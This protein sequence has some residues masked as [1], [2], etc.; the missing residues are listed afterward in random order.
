MWTFLQPRKVSHKSQIKSQFRFFN[1]YIVSNIIFHTI[2]IYCLL[3]KRAMLKT[4]YFQFRPEDV[5]THGT[6][7]FLSTTIQKQILHWRI[8]DSRP[9][10]NLLEKVAPRKKDLLLD[11]W[12]A[13]IQKAAL[14]SSPSVFDNNRCNRKFRRMC[15]T[16]SMPISALSFFSG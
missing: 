14:V 4:G 2:Q 13:S 10:G 16:L 11:I 6:V 15:K 3:L 8:V 9:F 5:S 1:D 12:R 7:I